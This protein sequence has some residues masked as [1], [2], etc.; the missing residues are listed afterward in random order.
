MRLRVIFL[1]SMYALQIGELIG[2]VTSL[3]LNIPIS[4]P[5]SSE[6]GPSTSRHRGWQ[7]IEASQNGSIPAP[8]KSAD[9]HACLT[10]FAK[11]QALGV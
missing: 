6:A 5:A 10:S 3:I 11:I 2:K 7:M 4:I 8:K 1:K 9:Q